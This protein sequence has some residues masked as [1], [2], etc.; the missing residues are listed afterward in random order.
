MR[1]LAALRT[2]LPWG[3]LGMIGLVLLVE[4]HARRV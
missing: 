2:S 4:S 3:F 1:M